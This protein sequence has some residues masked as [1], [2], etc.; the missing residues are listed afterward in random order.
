MRLF[1]QCQK[2]DNKIYLESES[3]GA[4]IKI[5]GLEIA[6][7]KCNAVYIIYVKGADDDI[8]LLEK[9]YAKWDIPDPNN[10]I[11]NVSRQNQD[12]SGNLHKQIKKS[13]IGI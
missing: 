12:L 2:C 6:C 9:E 8:K 13:N 4:L 7:E 11:D 5:E 1:Y 3:H 10:Y